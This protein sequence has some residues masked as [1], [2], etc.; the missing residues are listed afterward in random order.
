MLTLK[1]LKKEIDKINLRNKRVEA[2]KAWE[3]SWTRKFLIL[4]LTYTVIVI[5]LL[6]T[7][8]PDPFINGIIPAVAFLLSTMTV[9]LIKKWWL[10]NLLK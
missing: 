4:A 5:V 1:D 9:P 7:K 10:N 2:D 3:I 6:I 8:L